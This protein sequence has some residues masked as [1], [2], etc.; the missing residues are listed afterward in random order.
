MDSMDR[1]RAWRTA[2]AEKWRSL[3]RRQR[4]E[5]LWDYYRLWILGIVS[6]VLLLGYLISGY[7][8][9]LRENWF[10][11]CFANTYAELG[12]GSAFWREYAQYAGYD[13]HEKNLDFNAQIYCN[14]VREDYG[15]QYYRVLIA[16]MDSGT[17]DVLVMEP[18]RLRAVG[19]AGRLM[20][21]ED[22]RTA[23]LFRIYA[24]RLVWCEPNDKSYGR[25]TVAV[26]IDLSGSLLAGVDRAY[27]DAALGVNALSP[28]PEQAAVFLRYLFQEDGP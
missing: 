24:D 15:N 25:E 19:A 22:P 14:P 7:R 1:L 17:L 2:E 6:A 26:G 3:S 21:L 13:L 18:D 27:P 4:A 23:D 8:N 28:H 12:N 11:A 9:S 5:Y 16:A 20:D 10:S